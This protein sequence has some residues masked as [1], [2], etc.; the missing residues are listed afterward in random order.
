MPDDYLWD[1]S[2]APD[3]EVERL[4][5]LLS[6]YR[7]RGP[8]A[9]ALPARVSIFG[10]W[11]RP[12]AAVAGVVLL[13]AAG[14]WLL[15]SANGA[16]WEVESLAG[17]PRVG[18]QAVEGT[19]RLPV[20]E[21]LETDAASRAR[22]SVGLIGDV[23]VEPRS[24]LR[25]VRAQIR[26]HRLALARGRMRARIWAP[27]RL[28][29]VETPAALAV[30][31][32]CVYTLEVDESGAGLL[33]VESGWVQ[34]ESASRESVVPAGAVAAMSPGAGPGA[35]YYPEASEA[36]KASLMAL[37]FGA[38]EAHAQALTV[39]LAEA[40]REDSLTLLSLLSRVAAEERGQ[41]YD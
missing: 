31:L 15:R 17:T 12:I 7:H 40:R 19:G 10:G 13:V 36:F 6:A 20:G 18:K 25:L 27:P 4:E 8:A 38:A 32:G 33:R 26:D 28:F 41:V 1:R 34:L 37:D 11:L 30:D 39:V 21:W 9:L 3:S 29:F 14:F 35:P 5:E 16:G 23:E 2:G 24:R 22:I